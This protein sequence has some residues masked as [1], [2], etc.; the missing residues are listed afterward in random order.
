MGRKA[1]YS[2][3]MKSRAIELRG[4]GMV[5]ADIRATLMR[6]FGDSPNST[7][8]N[9][10]TRGVPAAKV[11]IETAISRAKE[12]TEQVEQSDLDSTDISDEALRSQLKAIGELQ[13]RLADNPTA[14]SQ[15]SGALVRTVQQIDKRTPPP[16]VEK[17]EEPDWQ[18]AAESCRNKLR[19]ALAKRIEAKNAPKPV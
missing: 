12:L 19:E 9:D 4:R 6:E 3:A 11:D 2:E 14:L 7:W 1:K 16:P 13:K 17:E 5:T 10:V 8:I 18:A 15:L